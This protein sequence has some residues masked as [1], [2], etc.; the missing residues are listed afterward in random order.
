M[1]GREDPD[2]AIA[3]ELRLRADPPVVTR[4]SRRSLAVMAGVGAVGISAVVGWS[5]VDHRGPAPPAQLATAEPAAS[6]PPMLNDLP[7]DYA[8]GAKDAPRLG[9]PLPGDLGRP[10][11]QA[12]RAASAAP[13]AVAPQPT[14]AA[15][16]A[17]QAR[18]SRLGVST[19]ARPV[20]PPPPM[21]P[22]TAPARS[23][24]AAAHRLQAGAIVRAALLTGI[25]S[26]LAGE[27][28]AQVTEDVVDSATGRWTLIPQ[29]AR[30]IGTYDSHVG[31]GQ[32]RVQL[33]W[34]RLLLPD[35]R[36]VELGKEPAADAAGFAGLSDGV[37]RHW[38][39]LLG[40]S[41]VSSVLG[42]GAQ[43]GAGRSGDAVA[44]ALRSGAAMTANQ[45]GQQLVGRS[46]D[47]SPSLTVRPGFPVRLLV[48][49][50]LALEAWPG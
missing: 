9:P 45:A 17:R 42:M 44:D 33:V 32:S 34:T 21:A 10:I 7:R 23:P 41:L 35:G 20:E 27:V 14:Q 5:L 8:A 39:R 37:D 6:P 28:V 40:A 3:R 36:S 15:V 43:A 47:V 1:S 49:K 4:L 22:E 12:G 19:A 16:E 11:L 48:T 25:R 31:F 29:G 38:R 13:D 18:A 24:P 30:L 46:L 26:D 50:D 2:R